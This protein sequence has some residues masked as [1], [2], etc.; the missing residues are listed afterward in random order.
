MKHELKWTGRFLLPLFGA[1]L[2]FALLS[3]GGIALC[4]NLQVGL[5]PDGT[6]IAKA[7]LG[8]IG[9]LGVIGMVFVTMIYAVVR[10]YRN[11]TGD[12][13]Y[14]MFTLPATAAQHIWVKLITATL[15]TLV[16]IVVAISSLLILFLY[17]QSIG[18]VFRLIKIAMDGTGGNQTVFWIV[19]CAMLLI[20]IASSYLMIYVSISIG[21]LFGSNRLAGSIV[22]YIVIGIV[23]EIL[24]VIAMIPC[25]LIASGSGALMS[26]LSALGTRPLDLMSW[27]FGIG[28]G[29]NLVF[30][31]IFFAVARHIF[32]KKLNL[33]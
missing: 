24:L 2:G 28:T 1:L 4:E 22:A 29:L 19:L 18:E 32:T 7:I 11:L 17:G 12:E 23:L 21:S 26:E 14:L 13:G 27:I 15:W 30:S 20:G 25:A 3:R 31:L 10:F 8:P 16:S 9:V 5:L 6:A 33:I